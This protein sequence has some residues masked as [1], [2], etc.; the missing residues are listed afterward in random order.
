MVSKIENVQQQT[1]ATEAKNIV[2][3]HEEGSWHSVHSPIVS[4]SCG[5]GRRL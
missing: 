3:R 1:A 5:D 2:M 4:S